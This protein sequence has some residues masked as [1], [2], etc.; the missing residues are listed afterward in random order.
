MMEIVATNVVAS[1]HPEG[2]LN[3]TPTTHANISIQEKVYVVMLILSFLDAGIEVIN[4]S[5]FNNLNFTFYSIKS[6]IGIDT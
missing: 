4:K 6:K 2:R 1:Q 3:A 5:F